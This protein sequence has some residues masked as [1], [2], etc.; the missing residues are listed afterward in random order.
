MPQSGR[1]MWVKLDGQ[2]T[3]SGRCKGLTVDENG[4]KPSIFAQK[5]AYNRPRASTLMQMTSLNR[6]LSFLSTVHFGLTLNDL[7]NYHF[8]YEMICTG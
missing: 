4:P 2:T 1:S 6:L 5:T 7:L 8:R 3:E